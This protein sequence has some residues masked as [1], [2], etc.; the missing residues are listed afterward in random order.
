MLSFIFAVLFLFFAH[1]ISSFYVLTYKLN[2]Y[3]ENDEWDHNFILREKDQ[4]KE[5]EFL[6]LK[7]KNKYV[8]SKEK[9]NTQSVQEIAYLASAYFE[10]LANFLF[11]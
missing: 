9:I 2:K 1:F 11:C 8:K 4:F 3:I 6:I 7:L 10:Y 5:L